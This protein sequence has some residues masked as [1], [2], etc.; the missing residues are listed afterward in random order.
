MPVKLNERG[1][2]MCDEGIITK[3]IQLACLCTFHFWQLYSKLATEYSKLA[4]S[5]SK[6]ATP[7]SELSIGHF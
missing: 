2:S 7:Y 6:L 5:C 3:D 1:K 4:S